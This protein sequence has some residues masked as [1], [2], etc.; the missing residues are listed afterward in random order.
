MA[1]IYLAIENYQNLL[2]DN[3]INILLNT[4]KI[5]SFFEDIRIFELLGKGT[6]GTAFGAAKL[7]NNKI[8]PLS[9]KIAK[10]SS[11]VPIWN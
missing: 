11:I 9:I 3:T 2:A 5:D 8:Y 10:D 7:I 6:Y 1:S 4:L